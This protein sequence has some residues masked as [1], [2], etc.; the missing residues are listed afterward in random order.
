M[1]AKGSCSFIFSKVR[2]NTASSQAKDTRY[3]YFLFLTKLTKYY[4]ESTMTS[5]SWHRVY[6]GPV[7]FYEE[8]ELELK[9][10]F[11]DKYTRNH[12]VFDANIQ[13]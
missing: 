10:L 7:Q 11:N 2:D 6:T 8:S 3:I 1:V 9:Y 5:N 4:Y 12:D 13:I